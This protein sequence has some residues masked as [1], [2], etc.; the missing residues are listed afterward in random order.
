MSGGARATAGSSTATAILTEMWARERAEEAARREAAIAHAFANAR[1]L[2]LRGLPFVMGTPGTAM[3][4][5]D[6]G[7]V[8]IPFACELQSV[9]LTASA[10]GAI[11]V[12]LRTTPAGAPGAQPTPATADPLTATSICAGS[13]PALAGTAAAL[14]WPLTGWSVTFRGGEFLVFYVLAATITGQ[15]SC[16]LELRAT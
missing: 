14:Y 1:P 12:D 5:G 10:A 8:R 2:G 16:N 15:I 3:T 9:C 6:W 11:T 4:P 7:H 13:P